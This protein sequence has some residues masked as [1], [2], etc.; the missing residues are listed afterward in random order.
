[1]GIRARLYDAKGE[2]S[3]V[4]LTAG[5]VEAL[6]DDNLLWV[7]VEEPTAADL[8]ALVESFHFPEPVMTALAA[9][10][11]KARLV[12]TPD[13]ILLSVLSVEERGDRP[14]P[15]AVDV[16]AGRN[17]VVT[18]HAQPV[19]ALGEFEAH[20]GD[21]GTLGRLDAGSFMGALVDTMLGSFRREVEEIEEQVDRL[22]EVALRGN[23]PAHFLERVVALRRR[24]ATLRRILVPQ[25]E[26]FG[27]L[28]RPDFELHDD[29]GRPWPGLVD[30][31]EKTIV[32]VERARELLVGSSD[33]YLGRLGQR[34]NEVMKALTILSAV[35]LPAVVLAGVMGMNF[36]LEFF[37]DPSRFWLVVGAMLGFAA[38]LLGVARLRKWI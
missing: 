30:R 32:G 16:V 21:E 17:A 26:T 4:E 37:D 35:L 38:L 11:D 31:L 3:D 8:D 13:A 7:D 23:D 2:D 25:R 15:V 18:V 22:D 10:G 6:T 12:R 33:V 9:P 27:P 14:E 20:I 1:M 24:A 34:A 19:S 28:A 29:L 5:A 36:K